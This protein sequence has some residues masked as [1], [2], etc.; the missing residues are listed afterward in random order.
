MT[1]PKGRPKEFSDEL[2]S[3]LSIEAYRARLPDP[4]RQIQQDGDD[5]SKQKRRARSYDELTR[6]YL[7]IILKHRAKIL[8]MLA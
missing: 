3:F 7:R 6:T 2:V 1:T 4:D 8:G 5:G